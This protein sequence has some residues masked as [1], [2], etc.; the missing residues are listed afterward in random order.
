M[1]AIQKT[2]L[3]SLVFLVASCGED[4]E[5]D[6]PLDQDAGGPSIG[7]DCFTD[8]D[9]PD[10]T[11]CVAD[12]PSISAAGS[13]APLG[14]QGASCVFGTQCNLG[15]FCAKD[16]SAAEGLCQPFPADCPSPPT[17]ACA[18]TVCA[19]LAGSS[20]SIGLPDN[21]AASITTSCAGGVSDV[22]S[23]TAGMTDDGSAPE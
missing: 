7:S 9:C 19:S 15:L 20:C 22:Q 17:C 13:C 8:I 14:D 2:L 11:V 3:A 16:Q 12:N 4:H 1:R 18:M 5:S 6:D 21:P 23:N 10:D